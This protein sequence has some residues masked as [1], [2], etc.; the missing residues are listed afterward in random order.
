MGVVYLDEH[1]TIRKFNSASATSFKLMPQDIGRPIDHIAYH[2]TDQK[3]VLANIQ[4]VLKTG[5]KSKT[6]AQ[7]QN[8]SWLIQ[9]IL[10]YVNNKQEVKGVIL[11]FTD[12]TELKNSE[13]KL[14]TLFELLPVG[15]TILDKDGRVLEANLALEKTIALS[16]SDVIGGNYGERSYIRGDGSAMPAEEF[17]SSRVL[18]DQKPVSNVETGIVREDGSLV[19][20]NVNAAPLPDGGLVLV[21]VDI[22][23]RKQAEQALQRWADIFRNVVWGIVVGSPDGTTLELM[24]PAFAAMHGYTEAELVGAPI[25]SIFAPEDRAELAGHISLAHEHGHHSFEARNRGR[26]GRPRARR[27]GALPDRQRSRSERAEAHAGRAAG[28]RSAPGD[29]Y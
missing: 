15:V 23:E 14:R 13:T 29:H 18:R 10:P 21:T 3:E 22:T 17:A 24:N 12:V 26:D 25:A 5:Q 16:R 28:K 27:Q 19:W 2:L 8:G 4:Q 9:R 6:E 1:L 20:I 7:T 11:T